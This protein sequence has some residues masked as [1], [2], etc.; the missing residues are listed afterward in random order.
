MTGEDL[1]GSEIHHMAMRTTDPIGGSVVLINCGGQGSPNPLTCSEAKTAG[2]GESLLRRSGTY[3]FSYM[4]VEDAWGNS[5]LY[6]D[7]GTVSGSDLH[8]TTHNLVLPDF[9]L[10]LD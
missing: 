6:H 1:E 9:T 8:V 10:D 2:I 4:R 7:D 5:A 3:T